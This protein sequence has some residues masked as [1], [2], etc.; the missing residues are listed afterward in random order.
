MLIKTKASEI[1][2]EAAK[3]RF[4]MTNN[5]IDGS[6]VIAMIRRIDK[7]GNGWLTQDEIF[8]TFEEMGSDMA[9]VLS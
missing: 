3:A 4:P 2:W 9:F 1:N 5:T 7:D 8:Q 6:K